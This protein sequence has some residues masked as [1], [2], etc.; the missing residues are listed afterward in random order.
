MQASRHATYVLADIMTDIVE[1]NP[2]LGERQA[3]LLAKR[4][5]DEYPVTKQAAPANPLSFGDR[6]RVKDGPI[7]RAVTQP[8]KTPRDK[9]KPDPARVPVPAES[10]SRHQDT[11]QSEHAPI[12]LQRDRS[13]IQEAL[14]WPPQDL[15]SIPE[16]IKMTQDENQ[17]WHAAARKAATQ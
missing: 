16:G 13:E 12:V 8:K 4:V 3:Y 2:G 7:T 5:I 1:C 11:V 14:Q 15:D 17:V 9:T 10:P 6:G